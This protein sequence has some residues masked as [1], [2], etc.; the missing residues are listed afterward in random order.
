MSIIKRLP[1]T[2]INQIAAGEV[3][4]RPASVL[5]ELLENAI[6]A[7]ATEIQVRI[8]DAGKT[9]I[10]VQDNG[11]G[12][13]PLDAKLCFERHATSKIHDIKDLFHIQTMGFRGEALASIASVAKV[14]LYTQPENQEIGTHIE[15]EASK[16]ILSEP[17]L[18]KKGTLIQVKN[19]FFNVPARRKFLKSN[20]VEF[21]H[22]L[23]EFLHIALAHPDKIFQ[24]Y[25]N[26]HLQF[27]LTPKSLKNRILDIFNAWNEENLLVVDEETPNLSIKGYV[28]SP[29]IAS[30]ARGEQYLFVNQRF[31]KSNFLNHAIFKCY[32]DLIPKD[33]FPF[34][35]IFIQ[36]HPSEIDINIH[37]TKTE[38]KFENENFVYSILHAAVR[39]ALAKFHVQDIELDAFQQIINQQKKNLE[40]EI[41][42]KQYKEKKFEKNSNQDVFDLQKSLNA[43][44]QPISTK[45]QENLVLF[46][47]S[48]TSPIWSAFQVYQ[49]YII[50]NYQNKLWIFPQQN[51]HYRI[52]FEQY[53][54]KIKKGLHTQQLLYPERL[55]L[56]QPDVL[57]FQE[58]TQI[59][60]KLGFDFY[61]DENGVIIKGVPFE[62]K[63][64]NLNSF[65]VHLLDSLKFLDFYVQNYHE[66]LVK[67][68]IKPLAISKVQLLSQKEIYT[69]VEELFACENKFYDPFGNPIVKEL[70]L[71]DLEKFF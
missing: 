31:I 62:L 42:I 37:P 27:H 45:K 70:K 66:E 68:I 15:I 3:V 19:L 41:T 21:K 53:L 30:N 51:A 24:L 8:Q 20:P 32:E 10:Q 5:K 52:L 47:E 48:A 35:V 55:H 1:D 44:Y 58:N 26:D 16:F 63:I 29:E 56:T 33:E 17:Y 40:G 60:E 50:T 46:T 6:D 7:E 57:I 2:L 14:S 4:Q 38:I 49:Q 13:D 22:L 69:M 28:G 34:F 18:C 61:L 9:L 67:T 65:V 54:P 23:N 59:F 25:A 12:M 43:L 11:K 36:V 39:K 71:E 64:G